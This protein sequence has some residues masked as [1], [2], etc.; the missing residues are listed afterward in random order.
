MHKTESNWNPNFD[1]IFGLLYPDK[2][3]SGFFGL[4]STKKI[5]GNVIIP[6]NRIIDEQNLFGGSKVRV[7]YTMELRNAKKKSK[8]FHLQ[9]H[10]KV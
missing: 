8:F 1:R 2:I 6:M 5:N 7:N 3:T 9:G 10:L 4:G